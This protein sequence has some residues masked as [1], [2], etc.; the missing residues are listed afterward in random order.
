M[1]I[2]LPTQTLRIRGPARPGREPPTCGALTTPAVVTDGQSGDNST[3]INRRVRGIGSSEQTG[4]ANGSTSSP[5]AIRPSPPK[6]SSLGIFQSIG[7]P[8]TVRET[9]VPIRGRTKTGLYNI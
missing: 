4:R 3:T 2:G 1:R 5:S 9:A 8:D 7:S 6:T